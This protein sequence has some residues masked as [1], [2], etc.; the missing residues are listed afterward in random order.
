ML[1][2]S[3]RAV[4]RLEQHVPAWPMPRIFRLTKNGHLDDAIFDGETINTPSLL[5]VEDYL[6]AL[7]WARQ[8]GGLDALIARADANANVLSAWVSERDWIDHL[9]ADASIRS[10]TS[11]CLRLNPA[12][13]RTCNLPVD[14]PARL[15]SRLAAEEVAYDVGAHRD[16]P[17]G[18]RI[19]CGA[20]VEQNDIRLLTE[21]LEWA[22][23]RETTAYPDGVSS[24]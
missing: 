1:I 15:A 3:P 11:V 19:W 9:A 13:R 7:T 16:A 17:P 5:C 2:L 4:E 6:D 21:W 24:R 20:T 18:L 23:R 10:N 14:L 8:I 22:W 12:P